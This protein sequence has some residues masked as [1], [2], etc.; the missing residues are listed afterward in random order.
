MIDLQTAM[1]KAI[2]EYSDPYY[3]SKVFEN[4]DYWIILIRKGNSSK[5]NS[6]DNE[7]VYNIYGTTINK[8]TGKQNKFIWMST[9]TNLDLLNNA[10]L[11]INNE[12]EG[13]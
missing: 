2:S 8:K 11:I 10:T 6:F 3:I 9:K 5:Y 4:K 12:K 1:N 13:K 7:K